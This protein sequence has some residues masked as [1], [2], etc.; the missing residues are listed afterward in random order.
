MR[1]RNLRRAIL[2]A[3]AG[4]KA[5]Q[6]ARNG[7]DMMRRF[8][9]WLAFNGAGVAAVLVVGATGL[10]PA[11][12]A[13]GPVSATPAAGTPQLAPTGTTEQIRQLAD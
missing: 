2:P 5:C 6:G 1:S 8:G 9:R 12:A 10:A 11:G 13:T 4:A 7:E 3:W